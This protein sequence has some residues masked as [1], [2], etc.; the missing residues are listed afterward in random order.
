MKHARPSARTAPESPSWFERRT[1]LQQDLLCIAALYVILLVLFR[2]IVFTDA[3]F[4]VEGDTAAALAYRQAGDHLRETEGVDPLWMPYIFS[5]MPTFGNVA[6]VPHDVSYVQAALQTLLNFL[7]LNV[8]VAWMIVHYFLGGLFTFLLIRTWGLGR[9]PALFAALT[10]M[11]S[12]Y[13][14]GLAQEGHGSKLQALSYLPMMVLLTHLLLEKRNLLMLGLFAAGTGTLLL[15]NHMQIVYYVLAV[16]AFYAVFH[17][18]GDLRERKLLA[19]GKSGLV[20]AGLLVGFAIS[21]Y[22]YLS[23]YEY[24]QYSIRGSGSAGA[25]GGLAWDYATNWSF[26]P[27]ELITYFIPSFFG[28]SSQYPHPWQGQMTALPLYWGTMPFTTSTMY[29]GILPLVLV[30]IALAYRRN[31]M[32]LFF[33]GLTVLIFLVSFGKHFAFFYDLLFRFLPFFNKFRA[34]SMIL[35]LTAFMTAV[36]GAHGLAAL[37]DARETPRAFD[38]RKFTRTAFVILGI[39]WALLIIGVLFQSGIFTALSATM[40][41]RP[42]E[43]YGAQTTRV[44]QELKKIR[45]DVLWGDVV[46]FVLLSSAV[47]GAILAFL[48][49]KIGTTAFGAAVLGLLVLDLF[50]M[51]AKFIRPTPWKGVGE[52]FAPDASVT[53]LKQQPG[54]F[55]IFPVGDLFMEKSYLFHTLQSIGGYHP[56]KLKIYQTMIDS[57]LYRGTDPALPVNMNVVNMLNTQYLV[58]PGQLPPGRLEPAHRSPDGGVIVYRNPDALP[59]AFFVEE[60]RVAGS[61]S[62]VFALLNSPSFNPAVTAVVEKPVSAGGAAGARATVEEYASRRIVVKASTPTPALLVLS[63]VYYPAGWEAFIDGAPT[64]IFKTNSILRSVVVPAGDHT[65]EFRFEPVMYA[66]GWRLSN[67]A[68]ILCALLVA[69]G[70][71]RMRREKTS[72]EKG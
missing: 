30:V 61:D 7:F 70:A 56:A 63:E 46:T 52:R 45:F 47:L 10:F 33:A 57:C 68:W 11:L 8:Q 58:V 16:V 1:P 48:H 43:N 50:L 35:Q 71:W 6:Y 5:G 3:M 20:L 15:T 59:R 24:S 32:T 22:I 31:R 2:G 9:L 12:P 55:R 13:A 14:I 17:A 41:E 19:A 28:F 21:S 60:V 37:L 69:A 67:G 39:L 66:M 49:R 64:E 51:D 62:D 54:L 53:F 4:S 23:V 34:P 44:L 65:V 36:I 18:A 29:V 26:H 72:G 27:F 25:P 40:F 42:G 38:V